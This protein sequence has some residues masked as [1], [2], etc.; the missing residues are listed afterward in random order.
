MTALLGLLYL[1]SEAKTAQ[2][3]SRSH[4][5]REV[6]PGSLP[7]EMQTTSAFASSCRGL[8][9]LEPGWRGAPVQE[10]VA[11]GC[12]VK[13]ISDMTEGPISVSGDPKRWLSL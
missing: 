3:C 13:F 6:T 10:G 4:L 7:A 5:G 2:V 9:D 8:L 1:P 11:P 12:K